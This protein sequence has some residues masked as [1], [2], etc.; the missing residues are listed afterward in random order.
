MN[1][2]NLP[3]PFRPA[4]PTP[5]LPPPV[6]APPA[7]KRLAGE[8]SSGESELESSDEVSKMAFFY[9]CLMS[10]T[11]VGSYSLTQCDD[12]ASKEED[13]LLVLI[14]LYLKLY[15]VHDAEATLSSS[16]KTTMGL[17]GKSRTMK[18]AMS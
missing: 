1:K 18:L 3:A 9:L 4:L 2:M 16:R 13:H 10:M 15:Q 12:L 5:P 11:F 8:L 14:F 6:P 7:E 17:V